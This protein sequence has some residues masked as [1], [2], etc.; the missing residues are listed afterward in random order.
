M[1][2]KPVELDLLGWLAAQLSGPAPVQSANRE[3][4]QVLIC[5]RPGRRLGVSLGP[6]LGILGAWGS[7]LCRGPRAALAWQA[8]VMQGPLIPACGEG[9]GAPG[10][11]RGARTT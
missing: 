10:I 11:C 3:A 6:L 2:G 1:S 9:P 5:S 8:S 4:E 7:G